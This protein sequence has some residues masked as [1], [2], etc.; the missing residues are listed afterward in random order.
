LLIGIV[1]NNS[2]LLISSYR[3][4]LDRQ[5][6]PAVAVYRGSLERLR[7]IL[8]TTASTVAALAPIAIDPSGASVQS[9]MAR[10]VIGG[11]LCSTLFTLSVTPLV[12]LWLYRRC[13]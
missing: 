12:C 2:I 4:Y 11:L 10:A 5:A 9:S 3:R 8:I 7:P 13:G 1:V 6:P